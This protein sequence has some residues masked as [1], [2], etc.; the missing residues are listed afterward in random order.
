MCILEI[1]LNL[2]Y[3][4]WF[5]PWLISQGKNIHWEHR[6]ELPVLFYHRIRVKYPYPFWGVILRD[7]IRQNYHKTSQ[8]IT[9]FPHH[10][11]L[12]YVLLKLTHFCFQKNVQNIII[13]KKILEQF[14]KNGYHSAIFRIEVLIEMTVYYF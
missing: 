6:W 5:W 12:T 1:Y 7:S 4:Y 3:Q 14:I 10:G 9:I 8:I 2:H 11:K 13:P